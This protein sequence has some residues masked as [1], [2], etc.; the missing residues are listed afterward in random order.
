MFRY[1]AILLLAVSLTIACGDDDSSNNTT[2][3]ANTN[4][5]TNNASNNAS[6]NA[7]NNA[8]NNNT[9]N[10]SNN[11]NNADQIEVIGTWTTNFDTTE[12]IT[13]TTWEGIAPTS[14]E[15]YDNTDNFAVLL[16]GPDDEFNPDKYSLVEWTEIDGDSF[17]YCTV[18]FGLDTLDDALNSA[19]IA[20][21]TDLDGEGCGGFSWTKMTRQ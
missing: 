20:D 13:A 19:E 1:R 14:I 18:D 5:A 21:P 15:L 6:N 3:N 7:T 12:V 10:E 11:A 4:N 9:T 2:N 16:N 8:T 17:Y